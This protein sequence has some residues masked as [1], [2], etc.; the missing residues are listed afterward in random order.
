MK[1]MTG[2]EYKAFIHSDWDRLLGVTGAYM[3]FSEV[4]VN[5]NEEPDD[6]DAIP[7]NAIVVIHTGDVYADTPINMS[8]QA[9]FTKW[10]KTQTHTTMLIRV[11]EESVDYMKK[12][13]KLCKGKVL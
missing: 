11:P 6:T 13:V 2:Y 12:Q 5:G 8:L 7:D 10:K 9:C 3:D 1:K 4:T